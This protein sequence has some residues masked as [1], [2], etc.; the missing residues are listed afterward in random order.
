MMD[1][2]TLFIPDNELIFSYIRASGPGGQNVNKVATAVQLRFDV[3]NSPSLSDVVKERLIKLAGARMTKD[4]ELV[5][6]AKRY[7]NQDRNRSDALARLMGLL[8]KAVLQ[9]RVRHLTKPSLAARF[10]RIEAKKKRAA[11]KKQRQSMD[12]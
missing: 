8:E 4:G 5:I 3:S 9:P 6:E 1:K 10:K 7:R 12:E 11:V 2:P